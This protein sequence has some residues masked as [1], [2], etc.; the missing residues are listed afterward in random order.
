[1]TSCTKGINHLRMHLRV[2]LRI[3]AIK[4]RWKNHLASHQCQG[5]YENKFST[6]M[7]KF[8]KG[9]SMYNQNIHLGILAWKSCA[10]PSILFGSECLILTNQVIDSVER[11]QSSFVKSLLRLPAHTPN[12]CAQL[13]GGIKYFRQSL[14]QH[15]LKYF[16]RLLYLDPNRWARM[17]LIDHMVDHSPYYKYICKI[18]RETD[19]SVLCSPH[20]VGA[21][22]DSHFLRILNNRI[23]YLRLPIWPIY[24]IK[25]P[26]H[27]CESPKDT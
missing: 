9:F 23:L 7:I 24:M 21:R 16:F 27:C 15:Q 1:M 25:T 11:I 18:R 6:G 3:I 26:I 10:V 2:Q 5:F 12:I 22:L 19:V 8:N 20:D 4:W 17:A 14:Y 13:E